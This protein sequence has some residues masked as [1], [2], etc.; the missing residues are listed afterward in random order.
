MTD[1]ADTDMARGLRAQEARQ[2]A[3]VEEGSLE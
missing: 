1:T 3:D 2:E